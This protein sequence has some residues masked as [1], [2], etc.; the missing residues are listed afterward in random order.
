MNVSIEQ[1]AKSD[2]IIIGAGIIGLSI[3]YHLL[4]IEPKL[5]ITVLEKEKILGL[6]STGKCTGG[7]RYQLSSPLLR[8]LSFL[9]REFFHNFE[10]V[11]DVPIWYREKGYLMLASNEALWNQLQV[12][13]GQAEA[14]GI[15]M[16]LLN[17]DELLRNY[18]FLNKDR[19]RGGT[20][21]PW[22][23][24]ADPYAVLAALYAAVRRQGVDIHFDR[25]A[26]KIIIKGDT[27]KGV[28]TTQGTIWS[29]LIVNAAGPYAARFAAM[30]GVTL[31]VQPFRRQVYV[32]TNPKDVPKNSPSIIDL[33]S[34]FYLHQEASGKTVLLGGTDQDTWPGLEEVVDKSVAEGF[35]EAAMETIPSAIDIK[36]LRTYTGICEQTPDFHPIIGEASGLKGL[37]FAN[38][39]SGNGFMHAPAAGRIM[40][41][42][43][44]KGGT[45]WMDVSPFHPDR[46]ARGCP[47]GSNS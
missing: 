30:G 28:E 24:Y 40:A 32:C 10:S 34:G 43:V 2:I 22:D 27:I 13:N 44:L 38:G 18:P 41:D 14:E 15:P 46:F 8:R 7:I 26:L 3:A 31:P 39:F 33:A 5:S 42:L 19:F 21:C 1:Q 29:P 4:E 16:R 36:W 17:Q 35:F 20:F 9:S 6:G 37:F 45:K 11:F 23:A 47:L 25:E 12:T